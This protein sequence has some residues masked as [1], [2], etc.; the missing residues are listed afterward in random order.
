MNSD[1]L[2]GGL[3]SGVSGNRGQGHRRMLISL[4]GLIFLLWVLLPLLFPGQAYLI[5]WL[6]SPLR[7]L[8]VFVHEMGHGLASLATGGSFHWFQMDWD[9][10][11]AITSSGVQSLVLLGG[12]LCPAMFGSLLL[13]VSTRAQKLWLPYLL[14]LIFFSAGCYYMIKPVF[15]SGAANPLLAHWH[16]S[17]LLALILP[18]AVVA[19]IVAL[20]WRAS[21]SLQRL[22]LQLFGIVMCYSAFS[23]TSYIFQ[24][25]VLRNGMYSDARVFA[26][27]FLP[28]SVQG[29]PWL[30]FVF[31]AVL[32]GV[33]NFALLALGVTR[34]LRNPR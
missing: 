19:S 3:A 17:H 20:L 10:G 28:F 13:I 22:V 1:K 30:A 11:V 21:D 25:E 32:I 34:A 16:V 4:M 18:L 15:L 31:F 29:L 9:G 2:S 5:Y 6:T 26:S 33:M 14:L 24:Y 23:D 12:L 8:G 27:L 7:L